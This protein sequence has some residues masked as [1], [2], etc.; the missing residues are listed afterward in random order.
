MK[1]IRHAISAATPRHWGAA[2]ALLLALSTTLE[3]QQPAPP[4]G[5]PPGAP[6]GPKKDWSI[7]LGAGAL[8]APDYEGSNNYK[9]VPAPLVMVSYRDLIFLRGPMLG[10]NAFTWKGPVDKL[11][12]GPLVR[13]RFG[14]NEDDSDDLR[15]MGDID[16]SIELGAFVNYSIGPWSAGLTVFQ[17]VGGDDDALTAKLSAGLR[18][19]LG[20]KLTLSGELATTWVD[21]NY[22]E[23][24]FGVT[25]K[26][27]ARTR[28][29]QYKPEGGF[30]D[31]GLSVGLD[32]KLTEG[33]G[34]TGRLGYK[35]L[36]GDAADSP[37]VKT[38]GSADQ[39]STGLFVG[40][41]F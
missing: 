37:L 13:Y 3:A 34:I 25:A 32:Y 31:A 12:V 36:L 16:G 22:M 30:K 40:Y 14:R 41:K 7:R 38:R 5:A 33:W 26:Q 39:F 21:D 20:P 35:R 4:P 8:Y 2:V 1:T 11:Q 15:G 27:S 28:L 29:R 17:G 10:A 6:S 19:P 18:L 23:A 9:I 24:Y